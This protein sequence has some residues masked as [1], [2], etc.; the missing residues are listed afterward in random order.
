MYQGYLIKT[1]N[2][3]K[4]QSKKG[5]VAGKAAFDNNPQTSHLYSQGTGSSDKIS[6]RS[7]AHGH[8]QHKI[9][10]LL[11]CMGARSAVCRHPEMDGCAWVYRC[12]PL[13]E[14]EKYNYFIGEPT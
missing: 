7:H 4:S 14:G 11:S 3:Q 13:K 10:S 6:F 9:Q 5:Q 2:K 1:I 12:M 8:K